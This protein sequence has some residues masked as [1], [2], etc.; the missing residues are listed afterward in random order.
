MRSSYPLARLSALVRVCIVLGSFNAALAQERPWAVSPC[1]LLKNPSMYADTL[2]SVSGLIL[3]GPKQFTA[4]GYECPDEH[5]ALPL[6]FGGD[7]TDAKDQFRL[8]QS[9]LESGTVPLRK[10]TDY[11]EMRRLMKEADSSGQVK[12]LRATL[13][14]RFFT[15]PSFGSKSGTVTY[16]NAR[17]VISEVELV[18]NRLEDPVDFTPVSHNPE[19]APKS[20][21]TTEIAV[22]SHEE[23]DK[24]QRLSREPSENLEYL[25]KPREVAARAIS[26]H[27]TLPVEDISRALRV[28]SEAV[29]LQTFSWTS[30]DASK[31]YTVTVNRPY[32]LLPS[33]YSGDSVIWVPER[34]TRT[35]CTAKPRH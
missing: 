9:R 28:T 2:V 30:A 23:E 18:S 15:G 6:V 3:Y 20:C 19:K 10:D 24:L 13:R 5:G 1:E 7:P 22:S 14:G 35:D 33:T 17:L 29:A 11:E 21:T 34:I 12:M 25:Q 32:W 4:H 8:P 31:S 26:T 16:P 27:E